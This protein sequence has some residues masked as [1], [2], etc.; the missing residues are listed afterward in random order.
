MCI[1]RL[2][3]FF[4]MANRADELIDD[5]DNMSEGTELFIRS[6]RAGHLDPSVKATVIKNNIKCCIIFWRCTYLHVHNEEFV[7]T[8]GILDH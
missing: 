6:I 5:H 3:P 2:F 8:Y 1:R 7:I 4:I